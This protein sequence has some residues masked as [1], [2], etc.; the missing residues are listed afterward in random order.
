MSCEGERDDKKEEDLILP[1]TF[2][3]W[4]QAFADWNDVL[5]AFKMEDQNYVNFCVAKSEAS[6]R[7]LTP[8]YKNCMDKFTKKWLSN[9]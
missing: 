5:K 7:K 3:L 8:F 6:L 4:K 1:G 9:H 2:D